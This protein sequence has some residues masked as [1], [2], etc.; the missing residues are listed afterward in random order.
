M[1]TSAKDVSSDMPRRLSRLGQGFVCLCVSVTLSACVAVAPEPAWKKAVEGDGPGDLSLVGGQYV[2]VQNLPK[3]RSG[4]RPEYEVFGQ[5]YAVLDSAKDFTQT[6]VASWYGSKFHGRATASGEIYDMHLLTAAHKHLPLPTFAKVTRLDT[7]QSVVVKIND[8]GPF[9]GDRIIDLSFG[10]AAALDML[11][12]GKAHVRVESLSHHD[13]TPQ[14]ANAVPP[15][16]IDESEPVA[17]LLESNEVLSQSQKPI[18]RFVQV[19]AFGDSDNAHALVQ[20]VGGATG[21]PVQ[22]D[23]ESG[24]Q[25]YRV[26]VGPLPDAHSLNEAMQRLASSDIQGY[27][28]Q[29]S[30]L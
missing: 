24:R 25:L 15:Q 12:S 4:N 23:F 26:L 9:V 30:T 3:S 11:D 27:E 13:T 19:G 16:S 14:I 28:V 17:P 1:N 2:H 18:S 6:G 22:L 5:R 7:G 10:A 29:K 20:R 8:R 21:L